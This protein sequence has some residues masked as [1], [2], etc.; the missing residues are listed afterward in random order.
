LPIENYRALRTLTY[1]VH[2]VC[3]SKGSVDLLEF[4]ADFI[5]IESLTMTH[6]SETLRFALLDMFNFPGI[7]FKK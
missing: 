2:S 1:F 7:Y 4:D 6:V 3:F 5:L